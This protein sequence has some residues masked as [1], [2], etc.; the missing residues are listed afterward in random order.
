MSPTPLEA[1]DLIRHAAQLSERL[2]SARTG[3]EKR[4]G[5]K[6]EKGWLEAAAGLLAQAREPSQG[7]IERARGLPGLEAA[8][9]EMGALFQNLWVDALERLLAGVTFHAGPRAPVLEALF[10]H[11]KMQ[12]LRKASREDALSFAKDLERRRKAGYVART[13][14][15]QD[16]AFAAPVLE[17]LAGAFAQWEAVY[18]GEGM[19]EEQASEVRRELLAAARRIDL[20]CRQARL[21]AEAALAPCAGMFEELGLGA[22]PKRRTARAPGKPAQAAGPAEPAGGEAPAPGPESDPALAAAEPAAPAEPPE[23]PAAPPP[24]KRPGRKKGGEAA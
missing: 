24:R 17:Q 9:D 4:R 18:S 6:A 1:Y 8:R 14:A 21:L 12:A 3:L 7:L 15:G 16:F 19:P 20:A 5:L 10:P 13:L 22:K 23:A 11:Q 2:A